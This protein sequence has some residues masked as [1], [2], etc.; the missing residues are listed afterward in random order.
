MRATMP[1]ITSEKAPAEKRRAPARNPGSRGGIQALQGQGTISGFLRSIRYGQANAQEEEMTTESNTE[2]PVE[3]RKSQVMQD[4]EDLIERL[5]H[6]ALPSDREKI[7]ELVN[8]DIGRVSVSF[9]N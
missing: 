9:L 2:A 3:P 8:P 1:Q 6:D 7:A 5:V 4:F